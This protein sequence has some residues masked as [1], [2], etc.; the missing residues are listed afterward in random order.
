MKKDIN[1][2]WK[3]YKEIYPIEST[4]NILHNRGVVQIIE[5]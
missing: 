3:D 1:K 2:Y 5:F 4:H